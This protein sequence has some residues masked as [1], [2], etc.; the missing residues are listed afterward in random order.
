MIMR[1]T[2]A[3][4]VI[5]YLWTCP[6]DNCRE[7]N[8]EPNGLSEGDTVECYECKKTTLISKAKRAY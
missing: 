3:Y 4:E 7:E 1:T 8:S 5:E 6:Y 2:T